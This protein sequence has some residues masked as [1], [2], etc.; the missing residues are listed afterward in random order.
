MTPAEMVAPSQM[1]APVVDVDEH[2]ALFGPLRER[3]WQLEG[4][5]R[6]ADEKHLLLRRF[7]C[8]HVVETRSNRTSVVFW[9]SSCLSS[10]AR[11]CSDMAALPAT[12]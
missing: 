8:L 7:A 1:D 12:K 11:I 2:D 6:L 10:T 3:G 5:V 4:V 9:Y